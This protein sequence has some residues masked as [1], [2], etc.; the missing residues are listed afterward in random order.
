MGEM[1]IGTRIGHLMI[2]DE[3]GLG[4]MGR[5]YVA[6]DDRL[7]RQVALKSVR[8]SRLDEQTRARFLYEARILSQLRH[9]NIC[10]IHG[11]LEGTGDVEGRDFLVLELVDGDSLHKILKGDSEIR[12]DDRTRLQIARDLCAGLA[13]AHSRGVVHRDL[14]PENVMVTVG[15]DGRLEVK[16]L[17]FGLA[18]LAA[19]EIELPAT[20]PNGAGGDGSASP[21]EEAD[22]EAVRDSETVTAELD[23]IHHESSRVETLHGTVYGT[24]AFMAPEQL[25]CEPT[26]PATDV[27]SLGLLFQEL[28]TGKAGFPASQSNTLVIRLA[29]RGPQPVGGVPRELKQL[30]EDMQ[31][32]EP[33]DRPTMAEARAR[34]DHFAGRRRRQMRWLAAGLIVL[35]AVVGF[36]KY[37]V[38][39]QRERNAAVAAQEAE[40]VS[41]RQAE[42]VAE[43]LVGLFESS[44]PSEASV[45]AEE[46]TA[47]AVL[48]R[49]SR[50]LHSELEDDPKVRARLLTVVGEVQCALGVYVE[51][52]QLLAEAVASERELRQTGGGDLAS[53]ARALGQ[54]GRCHW[55]QDDYEAAEPLLEEALQ[56]AESVGNAELLEGVRN[57]MA[58][59]RW[60]QAR[61]EEASDLLRQNLSYL[62]ETAGD[63]RDVARA[64]NNLAET[65]KGLGDLAEAERLLRKALEIKERVY[66]Q[67][68]FELASTLS[69][70]GELAFRQDLYAESEAFLQRALEIERRVFGE[71]H[72]K[73]VPLLNTLANVYDEDGRSEEAVDLYLRLRRIVAAE[74]GERHLHIAVLDNNLGE[75]Y[76][77]LGR[78]DEAR[79]CYESSLAIFRETLGDNHPHLSFPI[80]GLAKVSRLEGRPDQVEEYFRRSLE[81]RRKTLDEDHPLV[82]EMVEVLADLEETADDV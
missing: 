5:V 10:T 17:D 82:Q 68:H 75:T 41:R 25:V 62:D 71:D 35:L 16:I 66:G 12:L 54:F 8:Q 80:S 69:N 7:Q 27:Y 39:L 38:D 79:A 47:R 2:V 77:G 11:F 32:P 33:E 50:E 18:R 9:P 49:G 13:A 48:A 64:L 57:E 26:T 4:G 6:F 44:D 73:L 63:P 14:K 45:E 22:D 30:I 81:Q 28:F 53:L 31:S 72:P 3:L 59:L 60:R 43:F 1:L 24:L 21:D 78:A 70:L 55:E 67:G 34:L 56:I 65:T 29:Q 40:E 76:V 19:D 74:R 36:S 52:E 20:D 58:L 51:A 61:Y 23:W 37:T 15:D 42:R 46:L